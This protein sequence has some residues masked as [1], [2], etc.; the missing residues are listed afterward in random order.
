MTTS[1]TSAST[2]EAIERIAE[3]T[4]RELTYRLLAEAGTPSAEL[5]ATMNSDSRRPHKPINTDDLAYAISSSDP[6]LNVA[7][8]AWFSARV[9]QQPV[10]VGSLRALMGD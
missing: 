3:Q 7:V 1:P 2:L 6:E 5:P 10:T 8:E 4:R 9:F